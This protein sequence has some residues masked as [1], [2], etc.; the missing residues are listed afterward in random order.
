[1]RGLGPVEQARFERLVLP[2]VDAAFNLAF[3]YCAPAK[4]PKMLPKRDFSA[5]AVISADFRVEMRA[6]LLRIVRN[7]RYTW[8][9]NN[10]SVELSV[11]FDEESHL[12]ICV[13][14]ESLA[15]YRR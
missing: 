2:Y 1:M 14:P 10:R 5:H 7:T 12:Q 6:W 15:H 8:L 11:P 3:G 9:E 13:T 4:M